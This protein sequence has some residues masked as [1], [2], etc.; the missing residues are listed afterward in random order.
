[1]REI[2]AGEPIRGLWFDRT[3]E[4]AA[5]NRGE[6]FGRLK[7]ATEEVFELSPLPCW[8]HLPADTYRERVAAIMGRPSA[9]PDLKKGAHRQLSFSSADRAAEGGGVRGRQMRASSGEFWLLAG[10]HMAP[11]SERAH[12]PEVNPPAKMSA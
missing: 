10:D 12:L 7:Y 8:A 1:M 3:Q 5:R 9:C 11:Y 2:L 4:Y 6:D